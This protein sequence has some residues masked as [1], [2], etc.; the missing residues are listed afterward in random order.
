MKAKVDP[1]RTFGDEIFFSRP[2]AFREKSR[3]RPFHRK[4]HIPAGVPDLPDTAH[5]PIYGIGSN[6]VDIQEHIA[7]LD[8]LIGDR[9]WA[10]TVCQPLCGVVETRA[11]DGHFLFC[12]DLTE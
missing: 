1:V 9:L 3:L 11:E 7:I 10:R 12:I 8:L 5:S 6:P 2:A 4:I